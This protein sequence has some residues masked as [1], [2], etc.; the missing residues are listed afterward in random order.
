V[1][2]SWHRFSLQPSLYFIKTL[3]GRIWLLQ[4][5]RSR[6]KTCFGGYGFCPQNGFGFTL[7]GLVLALEAILVC[8]LVW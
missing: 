1:E 5:H 2:L 6:E 4:K 3:F 8:V 7:F